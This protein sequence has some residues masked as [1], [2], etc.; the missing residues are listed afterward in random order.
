MLAYI[1]FIHLIAFLVVGLSYKKIRVRTAQF[2]T[3]GCAITSLLASLTIVYSVIFEKNFINMNLFEWINVGALHIQWSLHADSVTAIMLIMVNVVSTLVHIYSIGYM[4]D[5]ENIPKF[6]S[7]LSLFTFFMLFLVTSN[8]LLQ[9]FLGWEGVGLCSY[10]LIGYWYK[11][12]SACNAAIKAFIVNRVADVFFVIGLLAIYIT[13]DSLL[14]SEIFAKVPAFSD[15]TISILG[16]NFRIIDFICIMLFIGC[17]GKSA[18]IGFHTW[19]PDAMEGPTPVSALIHAATMVTAGIFLVV[20]CSPIFEY[21]PMALNFIV[22][23]G[24]TTAFFAATIALVQNDIKRIIAYSTCSQLGYM[25]LACGVSA[26]PAA[27]FHLVTHAYFKALLFLGAGSVIHAMNGEQDITKM[28]GL[29]SK[30]PYTYITML[31]GSLS[32]SG[33][34]PFAGF[35]SKDTI[36]EAA[37]AKNSTMGD[38]GYFL[39]IL[40]VVLTAFYS[41]RLIILTFHLPAKNDAISNAAHE[42]PK[43]MLIPLVIL[44]FAATFS[45]MVGEY[46]LKIVDPAL[47]F[48][49]NSIYINPSNNVLAAIHDLPLFTKLLPSV[50]AIATIVLTYLVYIYKAD[51]LDKMR[52]KMDFL[53]AVFLNKY[54]FDEIYHIAFLKPLADLSEFLKKSMEMNFIDNYG[55]NGLARLMSR[56]SGYVRQIQ[57]GLLYHY[58][59]VMILGFVFVITWCFIIY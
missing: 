48:W 23:V 9:L 41:F 47:G 38:F 24:G 21:S 51:I 46:V 25:F 34:F 33:I 50:L 2:I 40:T 32:L 39:G 36:L 27:M 45:G 16:N 56:C 22:F 8:N 14:F 18:Q 35:F 5:D 7:F 58:A 19:L 1:V 44:S 52:K 12:E 4:A 37:I 55:P 31:I 57:T 29:K 17:M 53:Y 30:I 59:F 15:S 11:K 3:S 13:F 42:S 20:R 10:L 6:M 26:Y 43:V 49:N 54:Y 28:G